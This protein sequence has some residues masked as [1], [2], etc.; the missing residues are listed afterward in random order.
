M[1]VTFYALCIIGRVLILPGG[2]GTLRYLCA[3]SISDHVQGSRSVSS[4]WN[5][6]NYFYFLN[7]H[8]SLVYR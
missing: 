5:L 7:L 6:I 4:K 1:H 3:V 8:E 2:M